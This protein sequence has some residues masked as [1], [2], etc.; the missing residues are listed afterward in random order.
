MAVGTLS[1]DVSI[2]HKWTKTNVCFRLPVISSLCTQAKNL[3]TTGEYDIMQNSTVEGHS[4]IDEAM[5]SD[6]LLTLDF[7]V[8]SFNMP[9]IF[10]LRFHP[11]NN[12]LA[13]I[14]ISSALG[15]HSWLS[16][17][18]DQ[19]TLYATAWTKPD[20]SIAAYRNVGPGAA[21][22]LLGSKPV[23]N[24]PGYVACSSSHIFSVGGATGEVFRVD[25]DGGIGELAQKLEFALDT[26]PDTK[27]G[28][29]PVP[30]GD[31]GGLR[32]GAHGCDLSHDGKTMYVADIGRNCTWSFSVDD[33][34]L[35]E[36]LGHQ[37]KHDA[38]REDDG[39]RHAWPHPN[40][41][42]VYVVQEHSSMIDVFS[43]TRDARGTVEALHHL[44]GGSILPEGKDPG[45]YWADEVRLS[46]GPDKSE[47]T[48][49][50]AST[51]GLESPTKGYVAAFE[52]N[53]DG[54]L[55]DT[56]AIDILETPSSG[57]IANAIEPAPWS[58][59][60][61][62]THPSVQYMAMTDSEACKVFLLSFDGARIRMVN[63]VT[64]EIPAA[65]HAHQ[66]T[67]QVQP[68][69]AIWLRPLE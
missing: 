44:Q 28:K 9:Y 40:G 13:V 36:V 46:A 66:Q 31:F 30:H 62:K 16:L 58:A 8:G 14:N 61:S 10:T 63:S 41:Q 7:Y 33:D 43:I 64:L 32:H 67:E 57:G 35:H 37:L 34:A 12:H 68:A 42:V 55:K 53:R 39:P 51:R 25:K 19:R 3:L 4:G 6:G 22:E 59:A 23:R 69:T 11:Q 48:H 27:Q 52:L 60:L 18:P 56:V 2:G 21:L 15:P 45:D 50:F 49:L 24:K 65:E 47:P 54:T 38:P 26:E 29:S 20:S 5:H 1:T 17:S